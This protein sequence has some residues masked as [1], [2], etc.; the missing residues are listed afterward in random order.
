[1]LYFLLPCLTKQ[2]I[3][4]GLARDLDEE[5]QNSIKKT[6]TIWKDARQG[7]APALIAAFDPALSDPNTPHGLYLV[8]CQFGTAANFAV[9]PKTAERLWELSE[10]VV[11]EK[12]ALG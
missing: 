9:D 12:F 3:W 2:A 1:L 5:A 11:G 10:R 6:G 8:E 4:T 7:A